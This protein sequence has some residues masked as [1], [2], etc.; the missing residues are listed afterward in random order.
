MKMLKNQRGFTLIELVL[1]IVVLGI[2]GAVATVQFGTI[3]ADSRRASVDG[4][5]GSYGAQLALA[6]NTLK[7]LPTAGNTA[8]CPGGAGSFNAEVYCKTTMSG[9]G[10]TVG[11]IATAAG[12]DSFTLTSGTCV[13]TVSYTGATGAI[14]KVN[15]GC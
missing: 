3:V 8:A 2:L 15:A 10:V 6:V 14:T 7:A 9:T 5:F 11:A 13:G 1:I 12:V 4:S